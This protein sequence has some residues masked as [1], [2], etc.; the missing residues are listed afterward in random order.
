MVLTLDFF[1]PDNMPGE[2]TKYIVR[3]H[4]SVLVQ[5]VLKD[6][7]DF[8]LKLNLKEKSI[9]QLYNLII[10]AEDKI[11]PHCEEILKTVVYKLILDEEP[12]V[13]SRAYKIAELMGFY[14]QTDYLLPMM[15]SHLTDSESKNVPRFV[16]SGLTA[17]SAVIH[18]S[19]QKYPDQLDSF[20]D[21]LIEL[22][23]SSDFLNNENTEVLERVL[24]VTKNLVDAA[25]PMCKKYQHGLFKILL[26][27]GSIPQ[28]TAQK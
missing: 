14:V 12:E 28:M 24:L 13:S 20:M 23:V 18:H 9:Q 4:L 25:G 15:I 11:K 16:S 22:I 3:K 7:H 26:Q 27:L 5:K 21:K 1:T 19:T 10:C 8:S 2:G 17:F 6:I